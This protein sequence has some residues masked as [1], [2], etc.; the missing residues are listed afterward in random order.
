MHSNGD[1]QIDGQVTGDITSKTLTLGEGSYVSGSVNADTVRVCGT[2]EGE[3]KAS[4]IIL[5]KTAR[6]IGDVVHDSLA[7]EAGAYIDGHC[8][9]MDSERESSVASTSKSNGAAG[10][11]ETAATPAAATAMATAG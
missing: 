1:V 9:R 2:V 7:I 8:R 3:L 6:V 11:T 10:E 5:T 4:S